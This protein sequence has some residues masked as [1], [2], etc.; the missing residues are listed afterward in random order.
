MKILTAI[1]ILIFGWLGVNLT[2]LPVEAS[3]ATS[4]RVAY[5]GKVYHIFFHSLI[6]YPELA[7]RSQTARGYN[8]WMTTRTEFKR[9]LDKL[10]N[11][12]FVLVDIDNV[13]EAKL[14]N[15][16]LMLPKG[17][18]PLIISVDDVNYY[19]Y[20]RG[21]GFAD[22]LIVDAK[23]R[24]TAVVTTPKGDTVTDDEGDVMPI[25]DSFVEK[26]PDFS[27]DGAKGLV[28]VTGFQGVFGYRITTQKGAELEESKKQARA[29]ANALRLSGW[30]IACHSYS[31][32]KDFRD[33]SITL[34][35]LKNDTERWIKEIAAVT[36]MTNIYITP[37]GT[38]FGGKD[39]RLKYLISQGYHIFCPVYKGM[40]VSLAGECLISER[41]NF[42]GFTMQNYPARITS[43]FF[44]LDGI[45]DKSRP[46]FTAG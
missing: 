36:G 11:N 3:P 42:D 31:H 44:S 41:L 37:F 27:L 33:G 26:H 43:A 12:D 17:K 18:K 16:P 29:V 15:K 6:L 39:E 8:D 14:G 46:A 40:N 9:I 21:D 7:F 30:K 35:K 38:P 1:L 24:V 13:R 5:E 25:V 4:S 2:A 32:T 45:M 20:M 10:Y 23:G 28:A 19:D 22:R 34:E